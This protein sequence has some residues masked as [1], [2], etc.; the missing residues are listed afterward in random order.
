MKIKPDIYAKES[1]SVI[2]SIRQRTTYELHWEGRT[3]LEITPRN[4]KSLEINPSQ[5]YFNYVYAT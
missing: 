5:D 3:C 2:N 1:L 4:L